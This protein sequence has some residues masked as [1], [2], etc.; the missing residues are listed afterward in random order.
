MTRK[1]AICCFLPNRVLSLLI[2]NGIVF[3]LVI[4]RQS[5]NSESADAL[6]RMRY[7]GD[8]SR[9]SELA[10][11]DSVPRVAL[12]TLQEGQQVWTDELAS[13]ERPVALVFGSYTCPIFRSTIPEIIKLSHDYAGIDF[14]MVY[15]REA[16]PAD[17]DAHPRNHDIPIIRSAKTIAQRSNSA[18]QC[19][20]GLKIEMPILLDGITNEASEQFHAWPERV[21]VLHSGEIVHA[22]IGSGSIDV[23]AIKNALDSL[24]PRVR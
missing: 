15:I 6:S 10:E 12:T 19:A 5:E 21:V 8:L 1:N 9:K 2:V 16:H 7:W 17:F 24:S 4:W 13:Q 14:Y 18:V 3:G 23:F 11:G 22:G 20:A